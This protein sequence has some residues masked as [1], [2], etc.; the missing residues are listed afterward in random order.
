MRTSQSFISRLCF[1]ACIL[2]L[3]FVSCSKE[4]IVEPDP[5]QIYLSVEDPFIRHFMENWEEVDEVPIMRNN[6]EEYH[7]TPWRKSGVIPSGLPEQIMTDVKKADGW[8]MPFCFLN[9][10]ENNINFFG[11]YNSRTGILRLF[12]WMIPASEATNT[13]VEVQLGSPRVYGD[14][15]PLYHMLA[16]G[17][18]SSH[19]NLNNR[20]SF[21]TK[22]TY[23]YKNIVTSPLR[24]E[25]TAFTEGWIAVDMDM[26]AY[27]PDNT[28]WP[29]SKEEFHVDVRNERS[30]KITLNGQISATTAGAFSGDIESPQ[31]SSV[32]GVGSVFSS[33]KSSSPFLKTVCEI[34][35]KISGKDLSP[36]TTVIGVICDIGTNLSDAVVKE[37][38]KGRVLPEVV[39]DQLPGKINLN[40]KGTVDLTGY[41]QSW[42]TSM[43]PYFS[44]YPGE[45]SPEQFAPNFGRGV[46]SLQNDPVIYVLD[47]VMMGDEDYISLTVVKQG[48]YFNNEANEINLRMVQFLDP[49]SIVLNLN[50]TVLPSI[51]S[52]RVSYCYGVC[53]NVPAQST[54][55]YANFMGLNRPTVPIIT[56][57]STK[58]YKSEDPGKNMK[59]CWVPKEELIC[60]A[61]EE[62]DKNSKLIKQK[63]DAS[64]DMEYSYFGY[65]INTYSRDFIPEPQI[66]FPIAKDEKSG[67]CIK[68]GVIPDLEVL[69]SVV[70]KAGGRWY[71]YSKRFLPDIKLIKS[72]EIPQR[73]KDLETYSSLCSS[74][75]A[76]SSLAN[77]SSVPVYHPGGANNAKKALMTL[78]TVQKKLGEE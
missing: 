60:S 71:N 33:I 31:T 37:L 64:T 77:D 34:I 26:S 70:V 50:R 4:D 62:T 23:T 14:K 21:Y 67:L 12:V 38:D 32:N 17:I 66:L 55:Q 56:D 24:G 59:Y 74:K 58:F 57:S 49:S 47:D 63:K 43:V 42:V 46:W 30:I 13:S 44:F 8:E 28:A 68:D 36:I 72:S 35:K 54:L 20:E 52:V 10:G 65:D 2:G 41:L 1:A 16:Y 19:K 51:D 40:T 53:P 76:V 75:Q 7:S 78:K 61:L 39:V 48:M 22:S 69:V 29:G 9:N 18:P 5:Q 45:Q 25:S 73:I 11:L 3:T 27:N 6:V 15:Y